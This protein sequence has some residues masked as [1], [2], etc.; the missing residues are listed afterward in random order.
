MNPSRH[1]C[2]LATVG[3]GSTGAGSTGAGFVGYQ[4]HRYVQQVKR[5]W[6]LWVRRTIKGLLTEP[7][8][9]RFL[10]SSDNPNRIFALTICRIRTAYSLG[11]IRYGVYSVQKPL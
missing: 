9:R 4:F 1:D 5:T 8:Y 2:D 7:L 3:A 11:N 10:F 6:T